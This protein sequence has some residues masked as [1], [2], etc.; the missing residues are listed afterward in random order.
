MSADG[1]PGIFIHLIMV[2]LKMLLYHISEEDLA[3]SDR[4]LNRCMFLFGT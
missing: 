2:S 4:V 1:A 3:R